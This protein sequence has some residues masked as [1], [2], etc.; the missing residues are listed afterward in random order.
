MRSLKASPQDSKW[1]H[2]ILEYSR[3][4]ALPQLFHKSKQLGIRNRGLFFSFIIL[5]GQ[6]KCVSPDQQYHIYIFLLSLY[7]FIYLS[8]HQSF[9]LPFYLSIYKKFVCF[10]FSWEYL[11]I[12]FLSI[13]LSIQKLFVCIE[14][15]GNIY[16]TISLSISWKNLSFHL[17]INLFIYISIYLSIYLSH[18][19]LSIYLISFQS[20]YLFLH[21]YLY[22]LLYFNLCKYL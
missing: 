1:R 14:F 4:C 5:N 21:F 20:I 17:S 7:V 9:F 10:R 12:S 15:R 8:I 2:I 6:G 22:I 11:S 13:Y 3:F 16:I 19:Y 18:I